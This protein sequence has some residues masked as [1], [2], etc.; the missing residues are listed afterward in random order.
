VNHLRCTCGATFAHLGDLLDHR[1]ADHGDDHLAT[2]YPSGPE[3][4]PAP[5]LPIEPGPPCTRCGT[6]WGRRDMRNRRPWRSSRGECRDC[7]QAARE[8]RWTKRQ[9]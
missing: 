7:Y 9:H 2:V 3:A 5:P 8:P 6:A 1:V 4:C